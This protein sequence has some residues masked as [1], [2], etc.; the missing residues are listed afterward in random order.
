MPSCAPA[1]RLATVVGNEAHR[2]PEHRAGSKEG[3]LHP[4]PF[5]PQAYDLLSQLA[6]VS[7]IGGQKGRRVKVG[8]DPLGMQTDPWFQRLSI[9]QL[10]FVEISNHFP[11]EMT[12]GLDI[13][14]SAL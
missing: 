1:L 7:P 4:S 6:Q 13:A 5:F 8:L 14:Y 2:P 10:L 12:P 9:F 11:G 3:L